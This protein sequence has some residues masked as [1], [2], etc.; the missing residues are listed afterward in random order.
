ME[1]C[2]LFCVEF[3]HNVKLKTLYRFAEKHILLF[4]YVYVH[5][6]GLKRSLYFCICQILVPL[7]FKT[8]PMSP[9][10]PLHEFRL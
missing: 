5:K 8:D 2:S 6:L 9:V 1:H 4:Y 7:V 10:R 3:L